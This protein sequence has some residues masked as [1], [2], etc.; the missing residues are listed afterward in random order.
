MQCWR[1]SHCS[2]R[3]RSNGQGNIECVW[4][5]GGSFGREETKQRLVGNAVRLP[6]ETISNK[7]Q[8]KERYSSF[9]S[10][11]LVRSNKVLESTIKR[12]QHI[13]STFSCEQHYGLT[14]KGT[15]LSKSHNHFNTIPQNHVQLRLRA[16]KGQ[17]LRLQQRSWRR[18]LDELP[19]L[20]REWRGTW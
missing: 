13:S 5:V 15:H 14:I 1:W 9:E 16:C 11:Y 3:S 17:Y 12:K 8:N 2:G 6:F 4:L 10:P 18:C 7:G 19:F 20:K